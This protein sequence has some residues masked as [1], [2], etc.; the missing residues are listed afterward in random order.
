[1]VEDVLAGNLQSPGIRALTRDL[2]RLAAALKPLAEAFD[3]R[4]SR[5]RLQAPD[6]RPAE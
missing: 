5:P 3:G 6:L 4:L 2:A 1:L